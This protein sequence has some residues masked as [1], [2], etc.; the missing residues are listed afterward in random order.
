MKAERLT[1]SADN[2]GTKI[3]SNYHIKTLMLWACELKPRSWWTDSLNLVQICVKLL[4]TLSVW[5]TDRRYQHYFINNCNLMDNTLSGEMVAS[6]L[7]SMDEK[8]LSSWFVENYICTEH[9]PD[10]NTAGMNSKNT[11]SAIFQCRI[12]NS[13]HE[14]RSVN[15]WAEYSLEEMSPR[16]CQR[17]RSYIAFKYELT[18]IVDARLTVCILCS[19]LASSGFMQ[20]IKKRFQ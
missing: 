10:V 15:M 14:S 20:N 18:K 2:N 4:H 8:Y 17:P 13:L 1:E 5:L 11:I 6:E 12:A 9:C 16:L 3:L 7:M 19:N